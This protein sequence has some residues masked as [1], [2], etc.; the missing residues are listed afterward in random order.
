[1]NL[2]SEKANRAAKAAKLALILQRGVLLAG[3]IA[4]AREMAAA[5]RSMDELAWEQTAKL[6]GVPVPSIDCRAQVAE[7]FDDL[8]VAA[9]TYRLPEP[10]RSIRVMP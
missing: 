5:A 2:G 4:D 7:Y 10:S 1:M 3:R 9:R 8:D 6:A